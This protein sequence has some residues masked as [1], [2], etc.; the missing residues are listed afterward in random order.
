MD[1][2][3]PI[4]T[5]KDKAPVDVLYGKIILNTGVKKQRV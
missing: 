5:L 2:V 4:T 3:Q 1:D